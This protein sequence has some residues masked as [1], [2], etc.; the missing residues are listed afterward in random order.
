MTKQPVCR[1]AGKLGFCILVFDLDCHT[2]KLLSSKRTC[3][4]ARND[5]RNDS[6]VERHC[7]V[8]SNLLISNTTIQ[9]LP[10][11]IFLFNKFY[12]SLSISCFELF[13]SH[14][15]TFYIR[16]FFIIDKGI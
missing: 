11:R 7:E 14:D 3:F 5:S 9:I 16:T 13:F 15:S 2:R 1:Q 10:M 12:F 6:A 8:R 4:T